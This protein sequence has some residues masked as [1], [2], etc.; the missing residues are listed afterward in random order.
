MLEYKKV[1]PRARD[2]MASPSSWLTW[3]WK[4]HC[5]C[6]Q[7]QLRRLA[8]GREP[9]WKGLAGLAGVSEPLGDLFGASL[10]F[11]EACWVPLRGSWA[12][13]WKSVR[14]L[15][16]AS[17]PLGCLFGAPQNLLGAFL[18]LGEAVWG[19]WG[20]FLGRLGASRVPFWRPGGRPQAFWGQE[21]LGTAISG[22]T[23]PVIFR[24]KEK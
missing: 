18:E 9:I 4:M 3:A 12:P 8:D 17:G 1:V 2:R 16:A 22:G 5:F 10:G 21:S 20:A 23:S 14:R 6:L 24:K 19:R 15:G 13:L 11:C 7:R